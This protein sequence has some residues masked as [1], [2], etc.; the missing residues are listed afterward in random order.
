M[1]SLLKCAFFAGFDVQN[2]PLKPHSGQNISQNIRH[3]ACSHSHHFIPS[4]I[5]C[6][7][8]CELI[9]ARFLFSFATYVPLDIHVC[10]YPICTQRLMHT[11]T[12]IS[13]LLRSNVHI[14]PLFGPFISDGVTVRSLFQFSFV[15]YLV[16]GAHASHTNTFCLWI[17]ERKKK[18]FA[19][20]NWLLEKLCSLKVYTLIKLCNFLYSTSEII[21]IKTRF[22]FRLCLNWIIE[23]AI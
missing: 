5:G 18:R 12:L 14:M 1:V 22:I 7:C 3:K 11:N 23:R 19:K 13:K 8:M 17:K 2:I 20:S 21:N 16:F 9:R 15:L 10:S 6:V 4:I